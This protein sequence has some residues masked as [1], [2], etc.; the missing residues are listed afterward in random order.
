MSMNLFQDAGK[1]IRSTWKTIAV[2]FP[3]LLNLIYKNIEMGFVK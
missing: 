2:F 1:A 3:E